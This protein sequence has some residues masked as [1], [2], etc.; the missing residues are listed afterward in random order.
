MTSDP[1]PPKRV[2]PDAAPV[3]KPPPASAKWSCKGDGDCVVSC[4]DG[5]VA[6]SWYQSSKDCDDGCQRSVGRVGCIESVCVAFERDGQPYDEC[7]PAPMQ[8]RLL[9]PA[10]LVSGYRSTRESLE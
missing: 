7:T 3:A 4:Q 10:Q 5:A 2:V 9:A 6:K 1:P 8:A